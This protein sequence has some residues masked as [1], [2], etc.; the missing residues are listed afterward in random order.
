MPTD[1]RQP[2]IPKCRFMTSPHAS[3][4]YTERAELGR[5]GIKL[6]IGGEILKQVICTI[7]IRRAPS[8]TFFRPHGHQSIT[9]LL[10]HVKS[11][12]ECRGFAMDDVSGVGYQVYEPPT[13]YHTENSRTLGEIGERI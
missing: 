12:V 1:R 3:Q 4:Y 6:S 13:N 2:D 7:K 8:S 9:G 10:E 5:G 11:T